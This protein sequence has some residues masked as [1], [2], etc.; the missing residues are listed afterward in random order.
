LSQSKAFSAHHLTTFPHCD[1]VRFA[2]SHIHQN[3]VLIP[4]HTLSQIGVHSG[5]V[6]GGTRFQ[7]ASVHQFRIHFT[8]SPQNDTTDSA[9]PCI[10]YQ[11][12]LLNGRYSLSRIF[13]LFLTQLMLFCGEIFLAF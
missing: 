4:L 9:A 7:C 12:F 13:I 3:H 11:A 1:T 8:I 10:R 2:Q 5:G 6:G